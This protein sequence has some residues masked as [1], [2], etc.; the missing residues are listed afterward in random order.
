MAAWL[1]PQCAQ[2]G[3]LDGR[4]LLARDR[5]DGLRYEADLVSLSATHASLVSKY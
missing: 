4:L 5:P 3:D 1:P 2:H